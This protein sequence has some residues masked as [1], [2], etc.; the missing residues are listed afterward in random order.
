ML[1][2]YEHTTNLLYYTMKFIDRL[3]DDIKSVI[4]VQRPGDLD[5][6]CSLALLQEAAESSRR[7]DPVRGDSSYAG[8]SSWK[9]VV[10]QS[11]RWDQPRSLAPESSKT[12]T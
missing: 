5:T 11:A 1:V 12:P 10:P 2:T 9:L 7:P 4:L 8:R 3:R 6:A